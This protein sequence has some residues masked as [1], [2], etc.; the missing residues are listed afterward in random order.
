[1]RLLALIFLLATRADAA[2]LMNC[3][4][5]GSVCTELVMAGTVPTLT[6]GGYK[7]Y[8]IYTDGPQAFNGSAGLNS[9]LL[10]LNDYAIQFWINPAVGAGNWVLINLVFAT[11]FYLIFDTTGQFLRWATGAGNLDTPN[12][13]IYPGGWYKVKL[14]W[15]GTTRKIFI[16]DVERASAAA[17]SAGL[18]GTV[19]SSWF[20]RYKNNGF[21][22]SGYM[23]DISF[24]D[25]DAET[26]PD[27]SAIQVTNNIILTE[28]G[29]SIVYSSNCA[30][31]PD[32]AF[33]IL[34]TDRLSSAFGVSAG[35][36]GGRTIGTT[37]TDG[38]GGYL[39]TQVDAR[40]TDKLVWSI[41]SPSTATAVMVMSLTN[42]AN[43]GTSLSSVRTSL[44][45]IVTKIVTKSA[46][47]P[48]FFVT[49]L[50]RQDAVD[51]GPYNAVMRDVVRIQRGAGKKNIFLIDAEAIVAGT[52]DNVHPTVLTNQRLGH[53][54][55]DEIARQY[56]YPVSKDNGL[57]EAGG[58]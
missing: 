38:V 39:I 16:N 4:L 17:A 46:T 41:P 15:D 9:S 52:C 49:D 24:S 43:A 35:F 37:H 28:Y 19:A 55:A 11:E 21:A 45:S 8:G 34:A 26:M 3:P 20:G 31:T 27:Q 23:R 22:T 2:L 10:G 1:M 42:D 47:I 48:I 25:N 13:S 12:N 30:G 54:I 7:S 32:D 56:I 53:L 14:T 51:I 57:V 50:L 40:M 29:H 5:Q 18:L 33:R 58:E 6:F 44:D 36:S